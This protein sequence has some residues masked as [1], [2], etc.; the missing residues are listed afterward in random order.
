MRIAALDGTHRE[1]LLPERPEADLQETIGRV[2][3]VD[4]RH[5]HLLDQ[6]V[7][8]CAEQPLDATLGL[9]GMGGYPLDVQLRQRPAELRARRRILQLLLPLHR[10]RRHDRLFLSVYRASGR[11]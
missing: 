1:A 9:R 10:P 3:R 4:S 8:Q 5:T 7:L 2:Q 6:T 11:P